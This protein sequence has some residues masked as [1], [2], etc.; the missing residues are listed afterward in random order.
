MVMLKLEM[1]AGTMS[2]TIW[3]ANP[4][5][6]NFIMEVTECMADFKQEHTILLHNSSSNENEGWL[7]NEQDW[8]KG[9]SF[10][11]FHNYIS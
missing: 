6:L 7:E 8:S 10:I 3:V 4:T 5:N 11:S 1:Q 9:K 2:K